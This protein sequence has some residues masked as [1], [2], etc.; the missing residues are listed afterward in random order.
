M[1]SAPSEVDTIGTPCAH[2][3]SSLS[4]EPPPI[5]SGATYTAASPKNGATS[6][7]P[8]VTSTPGDRASARTVAVGARPTIR[9]RASGTP[10]RT[11]GQASPTNQ[12][13]ASTFGR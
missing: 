2:A 1:P 3:S 9:R 4:R 13:T 10:A 7:T 11:S 6:A 8:P 12:T 5:R